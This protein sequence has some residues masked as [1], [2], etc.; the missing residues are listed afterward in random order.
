MY[1]VIQIMIQMC[2]RA[3]KA[4]NLNAAAILVAILKYSKRSMIPGWYTEALWR[5]HYLQHFNTNTCL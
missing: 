2:C 1:L 4:R 3:T 5:E